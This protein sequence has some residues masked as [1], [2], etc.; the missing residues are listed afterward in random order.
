VGTIACV[1]F[2][3]ICLF[4]NKHIFCSRRENIP[5]YL[6]RNISIFTWPLYASDVDDE[7][8]CSY[9]YALDKMVWTR[10]QLGILTPE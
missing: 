6:N 2:L 10:I 9:T 5:I 3:V 1:L 8:F 7:P 4:V